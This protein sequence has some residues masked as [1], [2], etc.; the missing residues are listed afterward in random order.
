MTLGATYVQALT[1]DIVHMETG[2]SYNADSRPN[3]VKL[4]MALG[5]AFH[6]L[7]RYGLRS[8]GSVRVKGAIGGMLGEDQRGNQTQ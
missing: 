5:R 3:R 2:S 1:F 7:A 6:A 4:N 8:V